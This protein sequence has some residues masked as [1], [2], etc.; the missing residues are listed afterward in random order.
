M[1]SLAGSHKARKEGLIEHSL[2]IFASS[3]LRLCV[4]LLL[5]KQPGPTPL[6]RENKQTADYLFKL[7]NLCVA[8]E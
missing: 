6:R 1:Y 4:N 5:L 8:V 2:A 7:F 3:S